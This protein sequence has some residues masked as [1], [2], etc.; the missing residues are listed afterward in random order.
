LIFN[1]QVLLDKSNHNQALVDKVG[2]GELYQGSLWGA[3]T[4]LFGPASNQLIVVSV[5]GDPQ[6]LVQSNTYQVTSELWT[7]T[8]RPTDATPCHQQG[9]YVF[10][11]FFVME[12]N[13]EALVTLS[14]QAWETFENTSSYAAEPLGLFQP[15]Q[16]EEGVVAVMLLTWYDGFASWQTS[17]T[18]HPQAKENFSKRQALTLA[19]SAMATRLESFSESEQS[20]TGVHNRST[21]T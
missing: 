4:G 13:V 5:D 1:Y 2:R 19:T 16:S 8:A 6:K 21:S 10:R 9:L 11:R 7:P 15:N 12:D 17:R 3:F 18:P 14:K 20:I